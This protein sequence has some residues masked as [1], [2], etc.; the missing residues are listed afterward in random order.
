MLDGLR[1]VAV[2]LV[3]MVHLLTR[4]DANQGLRSIPFKIAE[5]G[6][7]GV[8]LFF[9]LSGFLITSILLRELDAPH[10][11][12]NFYMR[13][14]LRIFPLYYGSLAV[15]FLVIPRI[16]APLSPAALGVISHQKYAWLYAVNLGPY[17]F[18]G[19]WVSTAHFWSLAVEEQFYL[20]WPLLLFFGRSRRAAGIA[21]AGL[22]VSVLMRLGLTAAALL[23]PRYV[24]L[25]T[26]GIQCWTP[27]R[28]DGLAVGALVAIWKRNRVSRVKLER[29]AIP[30][31]LVTGIILAGMAWRGTIDYVIWTPTSPLSG[32]YKIFGFS[33][34]AIF[35]GSVITIATLRHGP[36]SRILS[37]QPLRFFGKYSYGLYVYH[38]LLVPTFEKNLPRQLLEPLAGGRTAGAFLYF[39]LTTI[40][41]LALAIASFHLFESPFLRLKAH[42]ES[43]SDAPR[44]TEVAIPLYAVEP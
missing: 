38:G 5:A 20:L 32:L 31:S 35:F 34:L 22:T 2:L 39:G 16:V 18:I 15:V 24:V 40:F 3:L 26:W 9:V 33:L 13:R 36:L 42:F 12:R 6:W 8:D 41:S 37:I 14:V 1:G 21:I 7:I 30:V 43:Q 10:Y 28:L 23:N 29:A 4:G 25:A 11:F 17:D 19:D 44:T 27:C